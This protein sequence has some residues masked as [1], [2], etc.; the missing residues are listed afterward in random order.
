MFRFEIVWTV[1]YKLKSEPPAGSN[2]IGPPPNLDWYSVQV[3]LEK[4]SSDVLLL[5]D[6]CYAAGSVNS[7]LTGSFSEGGQ[8]ELIAACGLNM[9]CPGPGPDSFTHHLILELQSLAKKTNKHIQHGRFVSRDCF[10]YAS[11]S[12]KP[13]N[14]NPSSV[15]WK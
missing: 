3:R 12:R 6:C 1:T 2:A 15:E 10:A 11:V 13:N 8:T 9:T 5:L 7:Y 14:A 4:A